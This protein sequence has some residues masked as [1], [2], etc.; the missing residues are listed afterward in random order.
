MRVDCWTCWEQLPAY[1]KFPKVLSPLPILK[2]Q[3]QHPELQHLQLLSR[4]AEPENLAFGPSELS[5][6]ISWLHGNTSIFHVLSSSL[7]QLNLEKLVM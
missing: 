3:D 2:C 7:M 4:V 6:L 1:C 5:H